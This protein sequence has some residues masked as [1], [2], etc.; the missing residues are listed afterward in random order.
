MAVQMAIKSVGIIK[1]MNDKEFRKLEKE[2]PTVFIPYNLGEKNKEITQK[3]IDF[4]SKFDVVIS[5]GSE[6][7]TMSVSEKVKLKI[8]NADIVVAIMTKDEQ[9][10]KGHW[11]SSKWII[12][13]LAYSL[14]YKNKEIIRLIENGCITDGRIFGDREYISF[15]RENPADAFIKLA[16][17]LNKKII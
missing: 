7:D 2:I 3:F 8:D 1:S 17:V 10:D 5:V 11:S 16:E 12:E 15:D 9:D 6:T 4:I 13:E 14:A